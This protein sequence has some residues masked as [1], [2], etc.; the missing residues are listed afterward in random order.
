MEKKKYDIAI[1]DL[2]GT[3]LNTLEDLKNAVNAALRQHGYPERTLEE[4]RKFVGNGV[5]VLM[6]RAVP[7]N[8]SIE[9]TKKCLESF[10][11]YYKEHCKDRTKPYDSIIELLKTL[12]MMG[13]QVGVVSNKFDSAVKELCRDFFG[14]AI[15]AAIGETAQV[16]KKPAPESVW[17][18]IEELGGRKEQALYIGDSEV[19]IETARNA[20]I[21][22]VSVTWGFREREFL[23]AKSPD[24]IIDTP[25]ELVDILMDINK[26]GVQG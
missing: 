24:Y 23:K 11:V 13:I 16:P 19:D 15:E 12:K 7:Q 6:D 25:M 18:A 22:V 17:K 3:L 14:D 2:D 8:T 21:S 20:G 5:K 4:V 9:N 10:C 26:E 1:F